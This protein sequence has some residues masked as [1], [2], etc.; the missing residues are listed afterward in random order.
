MKCGRKPALKRFAYVIIAIL[1]RT[2]R[3]VSDPAYIS[4]S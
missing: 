4:D 2:L 3:L 1:R